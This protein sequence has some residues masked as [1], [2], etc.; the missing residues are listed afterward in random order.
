MNVRFLIPGLLLVFNIVDTS[1]AF[2]G[3]P[4]LNVK[5]PLYIKPQIKD[6]LL[7]LLSPHFPGIPLRNQLAAPYPFLKYESDSAEN[8][9][10]LNSLKEKAN[11]NFF[12]R[13]LYSLLIRNEG[14]TK[15]LI[16]V[17]ST[18]Y[19]ELFAGKTIS[20]IRFKQLDVFGPTLQDTTL[21]A[22]SWSAE[23]ANNIH[24]KTVEKKLRK[25]LLFTEGQVVEPEVMADNEKILR[26]LP[27]IRDVAI[28]LTPTPG[29]E[30]RVDVLIIVKER[31]EYGFVLDPS[32][33]ETKVQLYDDNMFGLGHQ[34]STRIIKNQSEQPT[35]GGEITYLLSDLG[36]R[37]INGG[38]GLLNTSK[39]SG[40]N[41]FIEK[42]F[43]SSEI[44][45]AGGLSIQRSTRDRYVTPYNLCRLDTAV[46]YLSADAWFGHTFTGKNKY[47]KLGNATLSARYFHQHYYSTFG[48]SNYGLIRNH[49]FIMSTLG[50]SKRNLFKNNLVYGYGITEDIPYG[51]YFEVASGIDFSKYDNRFYTHLLFSKASIF[52]GGSYINNTIGIGGFMRNSGI[53]Q[54]TFRI[55][56]NYF[57]KLIYINKSP[58]RN[59]ISIDLLSGINRYQDEYISINRYYGLRDFTSIDVRGLS[60]LKVNIESVRFLTWNYHGFK[61]AQYFYGDCAFISNN[62]RN[63]FKENFYTGIGVGLRVHNESLVFRVFEMRLTWFP[64]VPNDHNLLKYSIFTQ[65]K[66]RF[67][68]FLGRK[69]EEIEFR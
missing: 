2:S 1:S 39:K 15:N 5:E 44:K 52:K 50:F 29:M 27:Y 34:F 22:K 4:V 25:Q 68:D 62:L 12:T 69:P 67:D 21:K 26:D 47:S 16:G 30:N 17:N 45:D 32:L 8:I 57:S 58:Y 14:N 6:T 38:I 49:D 61:F 55:N 41:A 24:V 59:F 9:R 7:H 20:S 56:M 43:L 48:L 19:F 18:L 54:G 42:K 10:Y 65:S 51:R 23:A 36:G 40:W 64:I 33:S 66:T 53:E 60:R 37:F 28:I 63:L 31:F 35:W 3:T 13:Q 11:S 46:S